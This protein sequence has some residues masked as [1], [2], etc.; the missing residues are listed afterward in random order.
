VFLVVCC[1]CFEKKNILFV[2]KYVVA[3]ILSGYCIRFTH[4][5]Q[6]GGGHGRG[7]QFHIMYGLR[8]FHHRQN[9]E[10]EKEGEIWG[11]NSSCLP[12]HREENM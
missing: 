12:K 9:K 1:K 10:E 11:K 2:Q 5:L 8:Q 4:T 3:S 7:R 6:G